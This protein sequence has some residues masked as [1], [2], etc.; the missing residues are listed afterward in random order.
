MRVLL[1]LLALISSATAAII[2]FPDAL[3]KEMSDSDGISRKKTS[4]LLPQKI[5]Y[6]DPKQSPPD[7]SHLIGSL[8]I[9]NPLDAFEKS[10]T[11]PSAQLSVDSPSH[12]I[13][14]AVITGPIIVGFAA[15]M[16]FRRN[17]TQTRPAE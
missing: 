2:S 9:T 7:H 3:E 10:V 13:T 4:Q 16:A 12:Q 8:Q 14:I 1:S 6:L 5:A 15:I 17:H 11:S